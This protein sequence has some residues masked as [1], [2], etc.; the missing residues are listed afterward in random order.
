MENAGAIFYSEDGFRN[1]LRSEAPVPHEVAHQWFGDS[2]TV[3]N[4]DH[5]WLSEG[6][7]TYLDALFYEHAD[8]PEAF[9]HIMGR[10]AET[11]L[12]YM[13][14]H[15]EPVIN[16]AMK[17]I[18][19]KLN[20]LNYEK[21]AWILHMLRKIVGDQRF[22]NGMRKY[23]SQ[24]AGKNASTEDF[25]RIME[26]EAGKSLGWFFDQWLMRPGWP[27]YRVRWRWIPDS[28][29]VRMAISQST[30]AVPFDM[31]IDVEIRCSDRSELRTLRIS[32][33]SQEIR[34][35]VACEPTDLLMDPGGWVL[36]TVDIRRR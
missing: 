9:Q 12:R 35:P 20:P 27:E 26:T 2:V 34:V 25:R 15:P 8:G 33:S 31:P 14:N 21:G 30:K 36:K 11:A 18:S 3:S 13:R 4:W 22:F 32:K 23:Y 1:N 29:E 28:R 6:F 10:A 5:I 16:P 19:R 24:Y 7:A 17:D